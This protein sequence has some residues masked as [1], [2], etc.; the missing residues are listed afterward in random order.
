MKPSPY[1]IRCSIQCPDG[2]ILE[3]KHRHDYRTHLDTTTGE[4]YMIDGG[5]GY[6]Y[7]TSKNIIEAKSLIVTTDDPFELQRA[8][9]F[10]KSYGKNAEH[11]PEGIHLSLEQMEDDHIFNILDTQ[12]HIKGTSV[13]RM[14][15]NELD[16][17]KLLV[18]K[19]M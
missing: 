13:E 2:T 14:F 5:H 10:W 19:E 16:Y 12:Q 11:Y 17:R 18:K 3:T 1:I 15:L 7:R 4:I 9:P 6:Y 8:I